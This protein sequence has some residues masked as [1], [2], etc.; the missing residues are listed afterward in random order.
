MRRLSVILGLATVFAVPAA[1]LAA[2]GNSGDG[3]LVV[4][5][6]QAPKGTPVVQLTIT[7][8][9]IGEVDS[10]KL[11]IDAGP[12]PDATAEPQVTGAGLPSASLKSDTA[13]VWRS[14]PG[15]SGFKF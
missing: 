4:K 6:G 7:G 10:G 3:S 15:S 11:V 1:A 5:S 8:S 2:N 14:I 12:N 9:V 13:Q